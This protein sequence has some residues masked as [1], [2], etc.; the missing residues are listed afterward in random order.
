M[1]SITVVN[2]YKY[3]SGDL[4]GI[5]VNIMRGSLLGNPYPMQ[6]KD[7][8]DRVCDLYE[9]WL[10]D[11]WRNKT[12]IGQELIRLVELVLAGNDL[13]LVCCCKPLRCH[14]D[15]IKYA[16]EEVVNHLNPA[17]LN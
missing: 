4:P 9:M 16:I 7:D 3:K 10:R 13:I 2:K 12:E 8:R 5:E 15:F 6:G 1:S 14:G 11:H 17:L